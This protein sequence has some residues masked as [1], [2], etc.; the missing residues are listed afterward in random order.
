MSVVRFR[1][2]NAHCARCA[3]ARRLQLPEETPRKLAATNFRAEI[4]N[5]HGLIH[6]ELL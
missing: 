5:S 1:D 2:A 3:D 6:T 4:A